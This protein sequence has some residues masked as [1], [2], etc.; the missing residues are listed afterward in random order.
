[1]LAEITALALTC[2]P[3]VHPITLYALIRHESGV[4]QYAIGVNRKA[5]ALPQQPGSLKAASQA[6]ENLIAQ[7]IDFDAGL[8]QINVRN[9]ARLGL[10]SI[11]VFDP[12][13]NLSAIQTVLADCYARALRVHRREQQ[14]LRAA[15]SC[16]NTGN[17]SRGF[18]NGYVS[19]VLAKAG[20]KVP[21]IRP[22]GIDFSQAA[23]DSEPTQPGK[24]PTDQHA[25]DRR[26]T[27]E[28]GKPDGF[29]DAV[30]DGFSRSVLPRTL[31]AQDN[32]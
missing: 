21:A 14:A 3:N 5:K 25:T 18:T 13:Q 11:T 26:H 9:W 29:S 22:T 10:D 1:M 7:G 20:I 6:A 27:P 32:H 15:M 31:P 28:E 24:G 12:C 16:Y 30:S 23:G 19:K 17:F 2:A 8:G 4:H